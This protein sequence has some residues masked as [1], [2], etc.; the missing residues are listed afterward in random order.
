[1]EPMFKNGQL[2]IYIYIYTSVIIIFTVSSVFLSLNAGILFTT[3]L[4]DRSWL[5]IDYTSPQGQEAQY[6]SKLLHC[7]TALFVYKDFL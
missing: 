5:F 6:L 3:S 4:T 2:Y 7:A 1:M